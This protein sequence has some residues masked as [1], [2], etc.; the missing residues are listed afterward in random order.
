MFYIPWV[1]T[2]FKVEEGYSKYF[3]I[4]TST[5]EAVN[6]DIYANSHLI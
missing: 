3:W 6:K 2:K 4:I 5:V 1:F